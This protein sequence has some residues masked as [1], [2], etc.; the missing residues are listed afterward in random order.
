MNTLRGA[1][2]VLCRCQKNVGHRRAAVLSCGNGLPAFGGSKLAQLPPLR[3]LQF[4]GITGGRMLRRMLGGSVVVANSVPVA[5]GSLPGLQADSLRCKFVCASAASGGCSG[6]L[7][8]C[9]LLKPELRSWGRLVS[10]SSSARRS[11]PMCCTD[12]SQEPLAAENLEDDGKCC[13]RS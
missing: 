7:T 8:R 2:E 1:S 5:I 6:A 12:V 11:V 10:S 9:S 13:W 3:I 4:S